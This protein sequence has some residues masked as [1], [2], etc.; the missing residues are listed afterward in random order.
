MG[1]ALPPTSIVGALD[2]A[3]WFGHHLRHGVAPGLIVG[4]LLVLAG[5]IGGAVNFDQYRIYVS[6]RPV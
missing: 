4:R 3:A 2:A 1:V 6:S 5:V